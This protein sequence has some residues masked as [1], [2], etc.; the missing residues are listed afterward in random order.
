MLIRFQTFLFL[1]LSLASFA[2]P[3]PT[4]ILPERDRARIVDEILED[5]FTNLLPQLMRREGLDM[6]V[7]ISREYNEDPVLKTML[8]STWLSARRRTIMVFFDNGKERSADAVEKLAIARYD[9]GNLLKGAWDI[10]VRP[11][12]WEALAKIIEDRKPKKIGL[13]FSTEY[14]HADGLTATEQREFLEKLPETYR[15]R[16]VSAQNAAV[17]WLETRTEKEM[18]IY[19][20]I[21]RLSHQIIQEGFSEAVIQPGVTT[22]DDVVWWF[23]Q[24]ITSLGLDTWFHPTVDVQRADGQNFEHLRTFSKRPDKQVIMPGDLIHVDFGITYL[25]LNT[26]QQQHAYIL[27]PG[28]TDVPESIKAAF[29]QGNRLQDILTEQ[30][31]AGRTGNQMLLAALDQA[32]KEGIKG[33]IYSHPIGVHGHAAGPTIGLWDQQKGVPGSG[34]YPLLANT[35]YSIELNAAVE[36]PEW[37]KTIRIMLEEDGFFDGQT[38]RYIDGRQTEI[39]TIPRK[40][41]Y[42]R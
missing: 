21:C 6:W 2:Q 9:V 37:K 38:F 12:Q 16:I 27:R 14:A 29:R 11:N 42:V 17:G 13:N 7:I 32:Q 23:R 40:L 34:D 41:G 8:P 18:A 25:R 4:A 33:T 22:T 15:K 1:L 3:A 5:R 20:M 39:Y 36:L 19:P 26:D 35:A 31:K 28:E 10:D 30:F 24:R